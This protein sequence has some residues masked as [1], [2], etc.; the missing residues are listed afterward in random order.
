M[1]GAA[2]PT[3]ASGALQQVPLP[4]SQWIDPKT[5]NPTPG[6]FQAFYSLWLRT[7]GLSAPASGGKVGIDVVVESV[8]AVQAQA[9][10]NE[11][12]AA[13]GFLRVPEAQVVPKASP[14]ADD[15]GLA[16]ALLGGSPSTA[17]ATPAGVFAPLVNGDLPGPT[18][19]ADPLG[20]CIMVPIE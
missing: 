11:S 1:S 18:L 15:G 19:I 8:T 4:A 17:L 12:L 13:I 5:G 14:G 16:L 10:A 6:F 20:Q 2:G 7:G 9:D 3:N